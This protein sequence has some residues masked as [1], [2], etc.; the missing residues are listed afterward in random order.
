MLDFSNKIEQEN[1]VKDSRTSHLIS[2]E[3]VAEKPPSVPKKSK[4]E[5]LERAKETKKKEIPTEKRRTRARN[6]S[7]NREKSPPAK[8]FLRSN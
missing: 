1:Q 6:Q 4:K 8:V 7:Q 3:K 2:N 5:E